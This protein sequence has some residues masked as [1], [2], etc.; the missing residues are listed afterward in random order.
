[1][2]FLETDN[3]SFINVN[4]IVKISH[5]LEG[6]HGYYSYVY[7]RNGNKLDLFDLPKR[8]IFNG[9]YIDLEADHLITI[10]AAACA[11]LE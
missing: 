2:K 3:G 9:E 5:E 1:M 7:L 11:I 10:H 8:F 6:N 4:E